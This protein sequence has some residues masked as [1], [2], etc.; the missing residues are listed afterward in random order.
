MRTGLFGGTFDP[1]HV[2]HLIIAETV[3]SDFPL[4]RIIFI[5]TAAPSYKKETRISPAEVRAEMVK[6][7][8]GNCPYFEVSDIEI[9][10][11]G[12]TYTVDTIRWFMESE[13]WRGEELYFIIGGDSLLDLGTWKDSEEILEKIQTL[14][15]ARPGYDVNQSEWR[16]REKVTMVNVPLV[17]IS[18]TEI[19]GR[20][21]D[22]KS[23]RYWV[24]EKVESYILRKGLYL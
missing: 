20:V 4:D 12:V 21:Q 23:I 6:L 10:R 22:G 2:G 16:F 9:Q 13:E 17:D 19:R 15:V 24:P 11:G 5:P 3:R 18:S 8:V 14:V 7:A 1:I